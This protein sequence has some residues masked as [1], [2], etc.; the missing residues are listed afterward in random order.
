MKTIALC[1]IVGTLSLAGD[2]KSYTPKSGKNEGVESVL[3]NYRIGDFQ[4]PLF[5]QKQIDFHQEL[6]GSP[7]IA[8]GR[9]ERKASGDSV[10]TEV[11]IDSIRRHYEE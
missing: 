8:Y 6:V 1:E 11:R 3:Q 10:R 2:L 9:L 7:V 5:G 4:F